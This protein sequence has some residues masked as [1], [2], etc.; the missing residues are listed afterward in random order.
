[1]VPLIETESSTR[2]ALE[3]CGGRGGVNPE[4]QGKKSMV[5]DVDGGNREVTNK[6]E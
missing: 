6:G 2:W 4:R 3:G 5:R 1:M